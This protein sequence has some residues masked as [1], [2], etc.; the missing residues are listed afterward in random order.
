MERELKFMD[1]RG[2]EP[3]KITSCHNFPLIGL[4]IKFVDRRGF[5]PLTS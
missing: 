1:R 4:H 5:E 3:L 2:F